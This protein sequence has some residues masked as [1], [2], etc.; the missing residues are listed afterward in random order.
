MVET[1]K[2]L[3]AGTSKIFKAKN[4][5]ARIYKALTLLGGSQALNFLGSIVRIKLVALWIGPVGIG[6]FSIFNN[7]VNT[8]LSILQG[9]YNQSA[10]RQ[11]AAAR[12]NSRPN[13]LLLQASIG[14]A[15]L[16]SMVLLIFA[17]QLSTLIYGDQAMTFWF[18]LLAAAAFLSGL[19]SGLM[20]LLQA[21]GK[22]ALYAKAQAVGVIGGLLVS[23]PLFYF[24]R[25]RSI[26]PS[27]VAYAFVT[28]G[29]ASYFVA[30]KINFTP[31]RQLKAFF[32][33]SKPIFRLGAFLTVTI[34]FTLLSNYAFMLWLNRDAGTLQVGIWQAGYTITD[35][36]VG[37]L[38]TALG[39]EYYPRLSSMLLHPVGMKLTCR[40]EASFLLTLLLI[41]APLLSLV[42][43]WIIELF[44]SGNFMAA[45]GYIA[46]SAMA[47]PF[48]AAAFCLAFV[49]LAH[50]NGKI[51]L[52]TEIT[53]ALLYFA[54]SFFSYRLWG[55]SGLGYG[56]AAWYAVY[57]LM[58]A[59]VVGRKFNIT[60]AKR[61]WLTI[62]ATTALCLL[63]GWVSA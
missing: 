51:Y 49:I 30:R 5:S 60:L 53:S 19:L 8:L 44:Y 61:Q 42:A 35:R 45:R 47:L 31:L 29:A 32:T 58:I 15:L 20:C 26:V 37:I 22:I 6:L 10:V 13:T 59:V 24:M 28:C 4:A 25:E 12:E 1:I 52:F 27:I 11:I 16:A 63:A 14:F 21:N 55:V 41:G 18:R 50:G 48:R 40:H 9:G 36:Y 62:G 43:P 38:F 46:G 3:R 2:T 33:E 17:R 23:I 34:V 56:Y 39:L 54:V 7:T 57:F